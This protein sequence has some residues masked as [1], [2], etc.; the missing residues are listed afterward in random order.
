MFNMLRL[1]DTSFP[2]ILSIGTPN[3]GNFMDTSAPSNN[4][5]GL[6]KND[7]VLIENDY[8]EIP[9]IG[10]DDLIILPLEKALEEGEGNK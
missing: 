4:L 6:I 8:F 2:P 5:S 9:L 3:E 1:S 10:E 7:L